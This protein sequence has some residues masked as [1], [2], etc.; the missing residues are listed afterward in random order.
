MHP[1]T[2]TF[3]ADGWDAAR[4]VDLLHQVGLSVG[5]PRPVVRT[6]LDTFDGL[7][8]DAGLRLTMVADGPRR[9]VDLTGDDVIAVRVAVDAAPVWPADLPA[10]PLRARVAAALDVRALLA[11]LQIRSVEREVVRYDGRRKEVLRAT[12]V[13]SAVAAPGDVPVTPAPML[14]VEALAGYA[15]PAATL[16]ETLADAGAVR[17]DDDLVELAASA[18]GVDLAGFSVSPT[19]PL[20]PAMPALDGWCAV[21]ANLAATARAN[22]SGTLAQIDTE[23]LHELRVAVRRTRS[24]VGHGRG[25]IPDDVL[26]PAAS[27]FAEIGA[28]TGP[29]RDFDVQLL[30]FPAQVA[31]LGTS[32]ATDLDPVHAVLV[33]RHRAAHAALD[34]ELTA[35]AIVAMLDRWQAW[36][37]DP[38]RPGDRGSAPLADAP[39]GAVVAKRLRKA[40]RRVIADGRAITADSEPE[41]LHDL[42]KQA[43]KLRYLLECFA[44]VLPS[45]ERK[46]FVK[47]LKVLQDNLGEHQD[48]AVHVD[49]LRAVGEDVHRAGAPAATMFALGELRAQIDAQCSRSRDEFAER[50]AEFDTKE[51]R[52]AFKAMLADLPSLGDASFGDAP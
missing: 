19:V 26:A 14:V 17:L 25:V 37:A 46:Q 52:R 33:E 47:A 28:V 42:R 5:N 21:L 39:L 3:T 45:D 41:A 50:F 6:V 34:T 29:A 27:A 32:A 24:I 10:G 8:H 31:R 38:A 16:A 48:A 11:V 43:K 51:T 30:D 18:A 44:S 23:F 2:S 49:E 35:P 15:K 1:S 7:L 9:A 22:W 40:H 36:L 13:E 20:D 12:L 4:L